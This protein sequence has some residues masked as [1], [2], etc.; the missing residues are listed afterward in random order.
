[1]FILLVLLL[2]AGSSETRPLNPTIVRVFLL[3]GSYPQPLQPIA[4]EGGQQNMQR[5][6]PEGPDAHHHYIKS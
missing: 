4:D 5:L 3:E 1:M 6:S 2:R